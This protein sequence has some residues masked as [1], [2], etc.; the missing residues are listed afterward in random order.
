MPGQPGCPETDAD[1]DGVPDATD[2]CPTEAET[3]NGVADD[4]GCPEHGV[5][6]GAR[7]R[8]RVLHP[9]ADD[10]G[11][12]ELLES[13]RFDAADHVLPASRPV[14]AQLAIALRATARRPWRWHE[15]AVPT[16]PPEVHGLMAVDAARANRRRDAVLTVLRELG[17]GETVLRPGEPARPLA[18]HAV[19]RGVVLVV[20]QEPVVRP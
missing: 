6:P 10:P 5:V 12:I 2:R 15:L 3:I 1:H 9:T 14:L 7:S 13:V 19:D 17:A 4:D 18:P 20:H 11:T 8:V 16:T